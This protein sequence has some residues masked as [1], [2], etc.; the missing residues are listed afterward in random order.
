M[1][2]AS[3]RV[4]VAVALQSDILTAVAVA[5]TPNDPEAI[6]KL[7]L[8]VASE[9]FECYEG[10]P[11][12]SGAL[13]FTPITCVWRRNR[14]ELLHLLERSQRQ[15]GSRSVLL[16]GTA[17]LLI[18]AVLVGQRF[19]FR[20]P[21]PITGAEGPPS[22]APSFFNVTPS[23]KQTEVSGLQIVAHTDTTVD[24]RWEPIAAAEGYT[25]AF[26]IPGG[27]TAQELPVKTTETRLSHLVPNSTYEVSVSAY[28]QAG[29]SPKVS[30]R[31]RTYRAWDEIRTEMAESIVTISGRK[32]WFWLAGRTE[33]V[34]WFATR[35]RVV[36]TYSFVKEH[37][38]GLEVQVARPGES[39]TIGLGLELVEF[40][41]EHDLALLALPD[42][43]KST[44]IALPLAKEPL[45]P[46]SPVGMLKPG[47]KRLVTGQI[48]SLGEDGVLRLRVVGEGT[49]EAGTAVLD[50]YGNVV[51]VVV[52]PSG[53]D[54]LI[55]FAPASVA[56]TLVE[57]DEV[58]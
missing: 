43:A 45:A 30:L 8:A 48:A 31:F 57:R 28:N 9:Y 4:P 21:P 25:V 22:A 34:G 50:G 27:G 10:A 56:L 26:G 37:P 13:H 6:R 53:E 35:E 41:E 11:T 15:R 20:Y 38:H 19:L 17:L 40:D 18:G 29:Q 5:G 58:R 1:S 49:P 2:P 23:L 36:T 3:A 33:S 54:G 46:G 24:L 39:K 55:P 32:S 16:V 14:A 44:P 7:L 51:G 12:S 47:A 52:G 42:D